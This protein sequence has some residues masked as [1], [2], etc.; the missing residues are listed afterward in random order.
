MHE[1]STTFGTRKYSGLRTVLFRSDSDTV[2]KPMQLERAFLLLL[3]PMM[4]LCCVIWYAASMAMEVDTWFERWQI[5]PG[6]LGFLLLFVWALRTRPAKIHKIRNAFLTLLP[7][8]A[9]ARF[10][11]GL[12]WTASY[13]HDERWV[14]SLSPWV[15]LSAC[16]FAFLIPSRMAMRVGFCYYLLVALSVLLFL[17][18]NTWPMPDG[19]YRE[20]VLSY[21]VGIPVFLV[22]TFGFSRLRLAYGTA[23]THASDM[24][25]LAMQDGL[26]GLYN[27]RAFESSLRRARS[28]QRRNGTPVS[29]ILCDI[30]FFKSVNDTYGHN[31]GDEVLVKVANIL[32][33]EMRRT[34]DVIRWGGEEMLIVLEET[35]LEKAAEVAERLRARI[36][37]TDMIRGHNVTAS[38]GVTELVEGE[39]DTDLVG[40]A[41]SAL[42]EAKEDGRNQVKTCKAPERVRNEGA[43]Q[44]ARLLEGGAA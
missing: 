44:I 24:E 9:F 12:I 34:D 19:M 18:F 38:F 22:L 31:K 21:I 28:R 40:R 32:I 16:M 15:T 1:Q 39:L 43:A 33:Q 10:A 3:L 13:G 23:L 6:G 4:A 7:G 37:S 14:D 30:D 5:L 35:P 25:S 2:Y 26:T 8:L 41:D 27:R 17:S 29:L 36:E 42:Y 11:L 20:L